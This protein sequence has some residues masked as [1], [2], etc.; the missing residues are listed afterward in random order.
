M[1]DSLTL[2]GDMSDDACSSLAT[3]R[4]L[5]HELSAI[6]DQWFELGQH[7]NVP[8]PTMKKIQCK[9]VRLERCQAMLFEYWV[10][11]ETKPTWQNVVD[12][13]E[14]IGEVELASRLTQKYITTIQCQ[15]PDS[16]PMEPGENLKAIDRKS[17]FVQTENGAAKPSEDHVGNGVIEVTDKSD[18]AK[19][20][21]DIED[22]FVKLETGILG[23]VER[24]FPLSDLRRVAHRITR[25]DFSKCSTFDDVFNILES[26]YSFLRI[27]ILEKLDS[28]ALDGLMSAKISKYTENLERFK[29]S[30]TIQEFMEIISTK[31]K[32]DTSKSKFQVVTLRLIG[33]ER[34]TMQNL[35]QLLQYLFKDNA[36]LFNHIRIEPGSVLVSWLVPS[37]I[38]PDVLSQA[39]EKTIFLH[40]MGVEELKAGECSNCHTSGRSSC[41]NGC[42]GQGLPH[43]SS[44]CI[45]G[46]LYRDC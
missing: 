8:M 33:W 30:C 21:S 37:A 38:V 6:S 26:H 14:A 19:K 39:K 18:I 32:L 46:R 25:N 31:A 28:I 41:S 42:N 27:K 9:T 16:Q 5:T 43:T 36:D 11:N 24:E 22:E 3:C 35:E 10:K 20:V 45:R 4:E 17:V 12:A 7:L 34:M 1:H 15:T 29:S 40:Q 44:Q 13:L 23:A 2:A